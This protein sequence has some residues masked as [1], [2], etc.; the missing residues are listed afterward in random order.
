MLGTDEG[1]K[2]EHSNEDEEDEK[3]EEDDTPPAEEEATFSNNEEEKQ[4]SP[5]SETPET[6]VKGKWYWINYIFFFTIA[7]SSESDLV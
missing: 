4:D 6:Q 1:E 2:T 5:K 3:Q 7:L